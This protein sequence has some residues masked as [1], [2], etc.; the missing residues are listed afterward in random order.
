MDA[1]DYFISSIMDLF[2]IDTNNPMSIGVIE[3]LTKDIPQNEYINFISFMASSK[4]DFKK[5]IEAVSSAVIE[6]NKLRTEQIQNSGLNSEILKLVD[7]CR[8]ISNY[9]FENKPKGLNFTIFALNATFKNFPNQFDENEQKLLNEIGG[10]KRWLISYDDN[11][12][13][14]DLVSA[15]TK[16]LINYKT[17]PQIKYEG[18]KT[19][20]ALLERSAS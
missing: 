8:Y 17:A 9:A 3:N 1:R 10:C 18:N 4:N 14:E 20:K 11:S 5:P 6:F 2:R 15:K 16:T 19:V 7:K 12:F 13:F